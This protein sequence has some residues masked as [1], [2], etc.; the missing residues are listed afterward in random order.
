MNKQERERA[1]KFAHE[2][3]AEP[4]RKMVDI[5]AR[6]FRGEDVPAE[7]AVMQLPLVPF[8]ADM[9]VM[10][11]LMRDFVGLLTWDPNSLF[12]IILEND[13]KTVCRAYLESTR[14]NNFIELMDIAADDSMMQ[15]AVEMIEKDN[16]RDLRWKLDEA[17]QERFRKRVN[18]VK[19]AK[20]DFFAAYADAWDVWQETGD[21]WAWIRAAFGATLR[22]YAEDLLFFSNEP[23]I[24]ARL[25]EMMT[26]IVQVDPDHLDLERMFGPLPKKTNKPFVFALTGRDYTVALKF[27]GADPLHITVD[28]DVTREVE[29]LS[30]RQ[31]A[32]RL[33]KM[34]CASQVVSM[35]AEPVANMVYETL[36]PEMPWNREDLKLVMQRGMELAKGFDKY[37][38][39]HPLPF[40]L[41][42]WVRRTNKMLGIPYDINNLATWFLPTVLADGSE[43]FLGQHNTR[44]FVVLDDDE[45]V[46]VLI[47][48]IYTG[49]TRRLQSIDPAKFRDVFADK[50]R[51]YET[52]REGAKEIGLRLWE[53]GYGYQ[54]M[55]TGMRMSALSALGDLLSVRRFAYLYRLLGTVRPLFRV[56]REMK[57]GGLV[58]YPDRMLVEL[59]NWIK[60]IGRPRIYHTLLN[61]TFDRKPR[62]R[63]LLYVKETIL[64]ALIVAAVVTGIILM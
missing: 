44:T 50:E 46:L 55:V 62:T 35:R 36:R 3:V 61:M 7:D 23:P 24:F 58:A 64:A 16:V 27:G 54:N 21:L 51:S 17:C 1:L 12:T 49:G 31:V 38:Y 37:W 60:K 19:I 52:M 2:Q 34:L 33:R 57:A 10:Y 9:R 15:M 20:L 8:S 56:V 5:A 28:R 47:L 4:W 59:E 32:K 41:K 63:G 25:R 14:D 18:W 11:P 48:E 13:D 6:I 22:V 53:E 26:S 39:M 30:Q 45:P 43:L 40:Y 29:G 42:D